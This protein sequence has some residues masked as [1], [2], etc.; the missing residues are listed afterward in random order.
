LPELTNTATRTDRATDAVPATVTVVPAAQAEARGARDVKDLFRQEVD[1]TV[2]AASPRFGAALA[3]SGRAGNEGVNIRGL[4]G[5]QVLLLVDG[6]RMPQAFT[7]GGLSVGRGDYLFIEATAAAEVLRGPASA[8]FGSDGLAGA[9]ALRTLDVSDVLRPGQQQ[10]GFVR[11]GGTTLD[12]S[13]VATGAFAWR[14]VPDGGTGNVQGL[15][16]ASTRRGQATRSQGSDDSPDVRRTAP[17]PLQYEQDGVLA[18]LAFRPAPAHRLEL[19]LEALRRD[20]RIE[21]LS[22][23]AAPPVPPATPA[24]TAVVDLDADDRIERS[25]GSLRWSYDDLDGALVQQAHAQLTLQDSSNRQTAFED[26]NTAADRLRDGTYRER[27]LAFSTQAEGQF[28]APLP[29]RLSIGLDASEN[30]VRAVRDGTVPPPGET[31]PNKPFPDTRYRLLGAFVQSELELGAFTLI[32][33]L[34][35]DHF[36]L[37]PSGEGF[38][39]AVAALSDQAVTP[40]LGFVWRLGEALRPYGQWSRGFRAPTPDQV[41]NGF[42]NAASFYQSIGNPDLKAERAESLELGLRGRAA[43]LRW[44]VA[45]YDNRYR[46]FISQQQVRGTYTAGDP[47]VFQFINLDDARVRGA[48]VRLTAQPFDGLRLHTAYATSKG[49]SQRAGVTTPLASIEP[50]RLALGARWTRGAF[51]WRADALLARAKDPARIPAATPPA[52]APPSY[53]VLDLSVSWRPMPRWALHLNVDNATDETYWRWSD[54]RGLASTSTV[55]DA[56]TAPPRT[57]T[58]ALRH[59]F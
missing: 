52:F 25:R 47:A 44:Q 3:G 55:R 17:N 37:D 33:A 59:D 39:G 38:V 46:D 48:E 21:V 27:L 35:F 13:H 29:Q 22:A 16:L 30:H 5:N 12:D 51:E 24:A 31:F 7:F 42:T 54:V 6:V 58:V 34:R 1:V 14:S 9:L 8:S 2:R 23:R 10:G 32:P 50:A 45:A 43:W 11:G 57:F 40:R 15:L 20:T 19:T 49:T 56:F 36:A 53:T 18:R 28:T 41:N 26:R 4:E